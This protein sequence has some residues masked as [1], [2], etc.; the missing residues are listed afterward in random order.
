[1]AKRIRSKRRPRP[2]EDQRRVD[3][4]G[5]E[6]LYSLDLR[7]CAGN[8]NWLDSHSSCGTL[9]KSSSLSESHIPHLSMRATSFQSCLTLCNPMD[10][11][12]SGSSVHGIFQARVLEWIVIF[13]SREIGRAHV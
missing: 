8:L 9:N 4:G 11:S 5:K 7:G 10:C 13:L 1:M 12:L 2:Q 3:L 6:A